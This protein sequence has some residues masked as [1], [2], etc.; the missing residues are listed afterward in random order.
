MF[1]LLKKLSSLQLHTKILLALVI[2]ALFGALFNVDQHRVQIEYGPD[3]DV[4]TVDIRDWDQIVVHVEDR[5][6]VFGP[7]DQVPLIRKFDRLKPSERRQSII[8]VTYE[9]ADG[10]VAI[11]NI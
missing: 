5:T 9:E 1:A 3:I 10:S 4:K 11:A 6:T 8:E 7:N 2:G